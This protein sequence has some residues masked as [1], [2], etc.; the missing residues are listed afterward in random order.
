MGINS[1]AS[2]KMNIWQMYIVQRSTFYILVV[3][4][5][6]NLKTVINA[7]ACRF[8]CFVC[9]WWM[10]N[11][12]IE[13]LM[14]PWRLDN[15]TFFLCYRCRRYSCIHV[16]V[17]VLLLENIFLVGYSMLH[18]HAISYHIILIQSYIEY[19]VFEFIRWQFLYYIHQKCIN[20]I[21]FWSFLNEMNHYEPLGISYIIQHCM[22][23]I[24]MRRTHTYLISNNKFTSCDVV[25]TCGLCVY[26]LYIHPTSMR[27]YSLLM[28]S[29][30]QIMII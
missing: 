7:T 17:Y 29:N 8:V 26:A 27:A 25:F 2:V 15:R 16:S 18:T 20:G 19:N 13:S 24:R 3:N 10:V 30:D 23:R 21:S 6:T 5:N 9:V 12:P 1:S 28:A 11:T 4:A 14:I 22:N